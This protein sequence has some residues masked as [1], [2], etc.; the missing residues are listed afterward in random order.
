[1]NEPQTPGLPHV[2]VQSTPLVIVSFVTV[3]VTLAVVPATI[4]E[5]GCCVMAT[6]MPDAAV[7]VIVAD[8]VLVESVVE[9]AVSVT[10]PA[11]TVEGAV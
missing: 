9:V 5:G 3:A 2:T 8:A 7:T 11:G 4:L 1:M 6:R 10:G